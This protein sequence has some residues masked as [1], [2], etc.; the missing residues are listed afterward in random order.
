MSRKGGR[1]EDGYIK[2]EG[3]NSM[4]GVLGVSELEQVIE[5]PKQLDCINE[6][7]WLELSMYSVMSR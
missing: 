6:L 5:L 7:A 2:M 4:A 3:N 1:W